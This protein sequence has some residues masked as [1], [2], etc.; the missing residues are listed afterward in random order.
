MAE[1]KIQKGVDNSSIV[2]FLLT[3]LASLWALIALISG[4]P[5]TNIK[6]S[7]IRAVSVGS[8]FL[9]LIPGIG[10]RKLKNWARLWSIGFLP[11]V[12]A[13]FIYAFY[14]LLYGIVLELP[15]LSVHLMTLF[16]AVVST[17][18]YCLICLSITVS[19]FWVAFYLTRP[20]VKSQF[21]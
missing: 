8:P 14:E 4:P 20:R 7:F 18:L 5:D 10:L 16:T 12:G 2:L 6:D 17:I 21:R 9:F 13:F 1:Q 19:S 3:G 11:V 15:E